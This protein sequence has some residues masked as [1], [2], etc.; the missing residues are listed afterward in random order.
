MPTNIRPLISTP[1]IVRE[2]YDGRMRWNIWQAIRAEWGVVGRDRF[3]DQVDDVVMSTRTSQQISFPDGEPYRIPET[4]PTAKTLYNFV[5][6]VRFADELSEDRGN[7]ISEPAAASETLQYLHVYLWRTHPERVSRWEQYDERAADQVPIAN[8]DDSFRRVAPHELIKKPYLLFHISQTR[9]ARTI[10][11]VVLAPEPGEFDFNS[12]GWEMVGAIAAL[13][14]G[15]PLL[16]R[17]YFFDAAQWSSVMTTKSADGGGTLWQERKPKHGLCVA[18]QSKN[19]TH[20]RGSPPSIAQDDYF[21]VAACPSDSSSETDFVS[22]RIADPVVT[23]A[24]VEQKKIL[25]VMIAATSVELTNT[26]VR[27]GVLPIPMSVA[28]A[29]RFHEICALLV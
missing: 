13:P 3:R 19:F 12:V 14:T 27:G 6:S 1:F 9:L 26:E 4:P 28:Q 22:L 29:A 18:F 24:C 20:F 17:F 8:L 2:H 11:E 5:K 25:D 7:I 10:K 15:D 16:S 23:F 21:V